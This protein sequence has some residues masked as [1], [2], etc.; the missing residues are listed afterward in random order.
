VLTGG[1]IGS[2]LRSGFLALGLGLLFGVEAITLGSLL[3]GP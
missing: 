1:L 3:R 2:S